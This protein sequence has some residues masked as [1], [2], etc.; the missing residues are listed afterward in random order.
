MKLIISYKSAVKDEPV[1]LATIELP[2]E[3]TQEIALNMNTQMEH[4]FFL[5][6][7]TTRCLG[8]VPAPIGGLR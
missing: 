2:D 3:I 8:R 4:A 1:T 5:D 6:L 7:A